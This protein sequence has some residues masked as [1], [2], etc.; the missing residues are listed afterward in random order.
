MV[1]TLT[2]GIHIWRKQ[3]HITLSYSSAATA[4]ALPCQRYTL[5]LCPDRLGDRAWVAQAVGVDSSDNEQVD[6]VGE[7]A[8][9]GVCF[10]LHCVSYSLPCAACWLA[11]NEVNKQTKKKLFHL[12]NRS[13]PQSTGTEAG[14]CYGLKC[15]IAPFMS[16]DSF[17]TPATT[18]HLSNQPSNNLDRSPVS[19]I[20]SFIRRLV[21]ETLSVVHDGKLYLLQQH[22]WPW[23]G[24]PAEH[25]LVLC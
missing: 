5:T 3:D 16:S 8:R 18:I 4:C 19:H 2:C 13:A 11:V 24:K 14:D 9:Y 12:Q 6:S 21:A 10:H 20:H 17:T 25:F 22:T 1:H 15:F 23:T 7:K